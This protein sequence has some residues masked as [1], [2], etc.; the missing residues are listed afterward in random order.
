M[1]LGL[2]PPYP[3]VPTSD[4]YA[5]LDLRLQIFKKIYSVRLVLTVFK[6]RRGMLKN[7]IYKRELKVR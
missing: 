6:N 1:V 5:L 3:P 2:S 4:A 7:V